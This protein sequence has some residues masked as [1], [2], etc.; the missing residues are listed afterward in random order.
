MDLFQEELRKAKTPP[1]CEDEGK[2]VCRLW[3]VTRGKVDGMIRSYRAWCIIKCYFLFRVRC[4]NIKWSDLGES[5]T[6]M[7]IFDDQRKQL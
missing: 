1:T 2:K 5:D 7:G 6:V 4:D 3:D